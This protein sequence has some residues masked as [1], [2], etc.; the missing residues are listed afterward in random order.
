MQYIHYCQNLKPLLHPYKHLIQPFQRV[1]NPQRA[2][3]VKEL[4]CIWI[5]RGSSPQVTQVIKPG[6]R[7]VSSVRECLYAHVCLRVCVCMCGVCARVC[8]C[9]CVC[10]H[11]FITPGTG[12]EASEFLTN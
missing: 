7:L 5:V 9:V 4:T 2:V 8:V 10:V 12:L 11:R 3:L 6:A 1:Q